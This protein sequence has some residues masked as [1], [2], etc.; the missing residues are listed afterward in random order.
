ME[1][2]S[3][4][5]A[6]M[7][8]AVLLFAAS[9]AGAE[10]FDENQLAKVKGVHVILINSVRDGCLPQPDALKVE[11]ELILRRSGIK[12]LPESDL[13]FHGMQIA[14]VGT[15][16]RGGCAVAL[17]VNIYRIEDLY[18]MSLAV[19]LAGKISGIMVG[20]QDRMQQQARE[21]VNM[22]ATTL[23]NKILKARQR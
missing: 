13:E 18:D 17:E 21:V 3:M 9:P 6:V 15:G 2:V 11:A 10:F 19:V 5:R 4:V 16:Q 12:V 1:G 23:A 14:T 20:P 8:A 22:H 7:L